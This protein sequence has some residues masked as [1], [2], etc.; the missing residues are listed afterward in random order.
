MKPR[1][2][3]QP[4]QGRTNDKRRVSLAPSLYAYFFSK[5]RANTNSRPFF[6]FFIIVS[7]DRMSTTVPGLPQVVSSPASGNPFQAAAD[8]QR[9]MDE[10]Q[11]A[12]NHAGGQYPPRRRRKQS[13]SKRRCSSRSIKRERRR[14]CT[15][16]MCGKKRRRRQTR[17]RTR[18]RSRGGGSAPGNAPI[19][20]PQ[21]TMTYTPDP[22]Q[23]PNDQIAQLSATSLQSAAWSKTDANVST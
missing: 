22:A 9:S 20:V 10:H 3:T 11:N 21:Y 8:A 7:L 14:G 16:C 1:Q 4:N 17:A 2:N 13:R 12:I 18:R 5:H 6:F 19:V 15:R 23:N